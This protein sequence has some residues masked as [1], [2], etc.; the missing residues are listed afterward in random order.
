MFQCNIDFWNNSFYKKQ[1]LLKTFAHS[2]FPF[3][4]TEEKQL[5]LLLQNKINNL[6]N[7]AG[8]R[9]KLL[10]AYLFPLVRNTENQSHKVMHDS[11][12]VEHYRD[13]DIIDNFL[14]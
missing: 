9:V 12:N 11:L 14:S 4:P 7:L 1:Y 2:A 5:S 13:N 6:M 8:N 3:H 10:Y